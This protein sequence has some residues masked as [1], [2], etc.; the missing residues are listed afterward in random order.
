M[1][2]IVVTKRDELSS[3]ILN[4]YNGEL[5]YSALMKLYR[6]KDIKVNGVRVNGNVAVNKNDVILVYYDSAEKPKVIYCDDNIVICDKPSGVTSEQFYQ[7]VLKFYPSSIFTHRLD[8]NTQGIIIFTL[9]DVAYQQLFNGFKQRTFDKYYYCVVYGTC[10]NKRC[11]LNGYLVKD[12]QTGLVK[13]YDKQVKNSVYIQTEYEV[14]KS[15]DK[16][17]LLKVKLIT[18]KTHQIRAHLAYNGLYILGDGK[19]GNEKINRQFHLSKQQLMA[20]EFT[21]NFEKTSPLYYLDGKTF[22]LD[23]KRLKGI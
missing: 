11:V 18:G 3:V 10:Q 12:S 9:N 7:R 15:Q 2:E 19:Y 4:G 14:L 5:S 1:K 6:K 20:G 21:F 17:S 23:L 13:I 8:T 22:S 16:T